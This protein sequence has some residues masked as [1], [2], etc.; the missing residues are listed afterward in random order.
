MISPVRFPTYE[1]IG[2]AVNDKDES[3]GRSICMGISHLIKTLVY[4]EPIDSQAHAK[5]TRSIFCLRSNSTFLTIESFLSPS[6][7]RFK[8][9]I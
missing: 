1:G 6:I 5:K 7:Q 3:K 9:R 4:K 2:F 8:S